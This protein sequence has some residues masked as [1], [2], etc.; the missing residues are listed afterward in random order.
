MVFKLSS[1]EQKEISDELPDEMETDNYSDEVT[2]KPALELERYIEEVAD[3]VRIGLD[4][5]IAILTPWFFNNMP[6][7]YYATTPKTE[8]IRHLSAIITGHV[9][10]TKQTVELWDR[11]RVK[12][13]YIGPGGDQN[14]LLEMAAKVKAQQLKMGA[15]YF[16]KDK[17]LF[18]ATFFCSSHI[19]LDSN[20]VRIME[21]INKSR[22]LLLLR[23]PQFADSINDF[24]ANLD[25]DFV[26]YATTARI[27]RTYT[28]LSDMAS[29]E[30][31]HTFV[32]QIEDSNYAR[33]TLGIKNMEPGA[34]LEQVLYLKS[35]YN[36]TIVRA[37]LTQFSHGQSDPISVFI[38]IIKNL[39]GEKINTND[40]SM[41]KL[42]KA[43]RTLSWVD[44]DDLNVLSNEP[45]KA[46]INGCNFLRSLGIWVQV[47]RGKENPYYY[48]EYK[49]RSTFIDEWE[50]SF[51]LLDLFRIKFDPLKQ[52]E[53]KSGAYN[54][55]KE[56]ILAKANA[57]VDEVQRNIFVE[58]LNFIDHVVKTNYFSPTKTGLA[59]RIDPAV[60]DTNFYT[61]KP[62]GI[63]FI[64]GRDY[65]FF[66]VRW[67]DI[68]RG[69]LRV[70]LP[71][72]KSDYEFALAG[73]FDEVYGLSLAQ[74]LKNK[75]I[76][77][78]GSKCVILI[79]PNGKR[80]QCVRASVNAL[81][82]LLVPDDEY[83]ESKGIQRV[84]YYH[85]DEIIYLGPD[86]NVTNEL[87][88][89][90][91]EQAMRR[92][93]PYARA[94]M[95]SKPNDGINHKEYGV[96]SEGVYV[97]L[98][99][100]LKHLGINPH[101]DSFSIKMTGG[102]D[103]DVGG[104]LLKI[105]YRELKETPRILT[106]S[107]GF[108]AAYDPAGLNWPE[109]LRLFEEGKSISEFNPALLS[110][111][112]AFVIP[113]DSPEHINIRNTIFGKVHGDIFIPA[114]G[115]PFTVNAKN[116][117][118]FIDEE[119]K[120]TAKGIVEG[121]NI[122]FTP[123]AREN[124]Q[125]HGIL[126]LKDSSANKTGVICSSY[127]I[128]SSLTMD[129]E[130]FLSLKEQ[131]VNEVI[132][133]LR[134]KADQ[135]A[136]LLFAEYSHQAGRRNLVTLSTDI[137]LEIN[138]I[139]DLLLANITANA[140]T[141]LK[142]KVFTDIIYDHCPPVLRSRFK[143]RILTKLPV[144]HQIALI[145]ASIASQIVYTEGLGWTRQIPEVERFAAIVTY[146]RQNKLT[147]DLINEVENSQLEHK[148]LIE[149]ILTRSAAR[150]LTLMSLEQQKANG[151]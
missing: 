9:F 63:F 86:E 111:K 47:L 117:K 64:V 140:D 57:M 16:S 127:E 12:V 52:E 77:E 37:F 134:H 31:T 88:S 44:M 10:E 58:C 149:T 138:E 26:T 99:N 56:V 100:M 148:E 60:L 91:P 40:I 2:D 5:S 122:F 39:S 141:L 137:S 42:N 133:I 45:Y 114:G 94:F 11:D 102:P 34:V 95:S 30:G 53:R 72:S 97:Y 131:Y 25:N 48:S 29:H 43:L 28:M 41:I 74:Q 65:R 75:D 69:G 103:G 80:D 106:I 32:E 132:D 92:G 115:R 136:N 27:E 50:L 108:G 55:L 104:N 6:R 4:Q 24:L 118:L 139:T 116:W 83:H 113:A 128:I 135:E 147:R 67:K 66:H 49:I 110:S 123:D 15:I 59:F 90:I 1:D 98:I 76:P 38:F 84:S 96:T 22:E 109:L 105:L 21:K 121:A 82:D 85:Q 54:R 70:I 125:N 71:R 23:Y 144:P 87:I 126:M 33:L 19:K 151:T 142:D 13:T 14:I 18:L 81:L 129:K 107:D 119:G 68:S 61:Q 79:K 93:Y 145:S 146:L 17:L 36:F 124:L 150:A 73:L 8:K 20:N 143:D 3:T 101:K 62:F 130:E 7:V 112:K 120:P 89:W 51:Q 78:G 35:R 46:S